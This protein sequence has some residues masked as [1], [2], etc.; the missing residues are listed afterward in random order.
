VLFRSE[1]VGQSVQGGFVM[2]VS[3]PLPLTSRPAL[4]CDEV[5][6]TE[7]YVV[8]NRC[9]FVSGLSCLPCRVLDKGSEIVNSVLEFSCRLNP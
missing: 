6:N 9:R 2:R 1:S 4:F 5:S 8:R 3:S 7:R